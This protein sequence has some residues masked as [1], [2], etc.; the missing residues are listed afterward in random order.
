MTAEE[1]ILTQAITKDLFGPA[2]LTEPT[3]LNIPEKYELVRSLGRG[4]FGVVYLAMDKSLDRPVALKFLNDARPMDIERFRREARFT[5]RLDNP[6]IVRIYEFGETDRQPYIAM[7]YVD[8]GSLSQAK[9]GLTEMIRVMRDVASALGHAHREGIVHRDFK[10]AN[11]LVDHSGRAYITDFGIAR[12]LTGSAGATISHDGT[13]MGTPALMPPEQARGDLHSVDARSDIYS[14]G[15]SL[16]LLLCGRYPFNGDNL[17]DVLHAVIH[18]DPPM[19][20][21]INAN[22]PRAIEAVVLKCLQKQRRHRFQ[23]ISEVR[24]QLDGFLEGGTDPSQ[25]SAWFRKLVGVKPA[26]AESDSDPLQSLSLEINRELANWDATL[27]RVSRN[28]HRY[29]PQLDDII[30]RLGEVLENHPDFAWARFYRGM[31]LFRRGCLDLALDDMERAIDRLANQATAQ[32]EMGRL[33]LALFLREHE[34]AHKHISKSGM[35][36]HLGESRDRLRQAEVALRE[37][38]RLKKDVLPWQ[39]DLAR[40][41]GRLADEDVDGCIEICDRMLADDPDLE[42][43]WKLHGDALRLAGRE[44]FESYEQALSV[45]RSFFQAA[46]AAGN[47]YFEKG[48][49]AKGRESLEQALQIHPENVESLAMLARSYLLEARETDSDKIT[50]IERGLKNIDHALSLSDGGYDLF[51]TRAEL[52]IEKSRAQS[53]PESMTEAIS[54]LSSA[55]AFPGCSNRLMFLTANALIE[56]YEMGGSDNPAEDMQ[57]VITLGGPAISN[58]PDQNFWVDVVDRA[59]SLLSDL[60]K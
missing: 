40:A 34:Q 3:E 49:I 4:G 24:D 37:T 41:V 58:E 56:R 2:G 13:V 51:V 47:A 17:V 31:A 9:L 30:E 14:F 43:V 18:D 54:A 8:G 60:N 7:Q 52:L 48:D 44:P 21:S 29:Y 35:R 57:R 22:I 26:E 19:P 39:A 5:A 10:P 42:E 23:T 28:I 59:K 45:R 25:S 6:A 46:I 27:Y 50:L 53:A 36:A 11:I 38:A 32:F 12:D 33:Y 55:E 1:S 20:R 15:A 16:Y